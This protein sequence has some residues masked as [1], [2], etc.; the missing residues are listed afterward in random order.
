MTLAIAPLAE[1][2]VETLCALARGDLARITTRPSSARRRPNTCSRSATIRTSSA[3]SSRAGAIW[4]DTLAEDERSSRSR[5]LFP[6]RAGRAVKID[7]LYVHPE[8]QRLG[9]GGA[10]IEHTCERAQRLGYAQGPARGEQAQ[11]LRD[12]RVPQARFRDRRGGGEGHR[13]RVRDG[14]LRHGEKALK[15]KFTKMHG[16][17]NDF[18]VLDATSQPIALTP[19]AA[20]LSSPTGISA[21]A[22]TRSSRSSPPREPGT[23]FY[24]RIFNADGGE[25]EQCGNGARCFVRYVHERGLTARREIRVG[26]ARRRDRAAARSRRPGDGR[27]GRAGVR[28]RRECLSTRL[29]VRSP[30]TSTS[31]DGWS[32]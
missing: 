24:Y 29:R 13:R 20:A 12:R 6:W 11:R 31:R 23:D 27:H 25:V 18:V 1:H 17:G 5:R 16:L 21:S 3:R 32:R 14:R 8:R 2:E 22:A 19:G 10:L 4:W 15:L 26:T 28:A 30:I 9:Y 7:K